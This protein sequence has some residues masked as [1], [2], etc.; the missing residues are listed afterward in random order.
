M[1]KTI[2]ASN[3]NGTFKY[4]PDLGFV[5][6]ILAVYLKMTAVASS[7]PQNAVVERLGQTEIFGEIPNQTVAGT[8]VG[9][10]GV[11]RSSNAT[12]YTEWNQYPI[13]SNSDG[14]EIVLTLPS[15]ASCTY[16]IVYDERT[17]VEAI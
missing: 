4:V 16:Y 5:W 3:S 10:G 11:S 6:K 7:G 14:I 8:Y 1:I 12:T 13:V 2:G 15:G 9:Q 17:E